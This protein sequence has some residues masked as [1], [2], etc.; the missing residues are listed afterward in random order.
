MLKF[1]SLKSQKFKALTNKQMA[2]VKGGEATPGGSKVIGTYTVRRPSQESFNGKIIV[3][4]VD[5]TV[6][7]VRSWS[8]DDLTDGFTCFENE[9]ICDM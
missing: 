4:Y 3:T 1:E 7:R 8:G 6:T 2:A 5:V 9:E